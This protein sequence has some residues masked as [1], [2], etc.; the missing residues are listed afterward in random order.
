M[1]PMMLFMAI[2]AGMGGGTPGAL[3]MTMGFGIVTGF[4][5]VGALV[6]ALVWGATAHVLLSWTASPAGPMRRTFQAILFSAGAVTAT[7]V[8]CVGWYFG[9]IWWPVSAVLMVREAQRVSG[10]KAAFAVLAWPVVSLILGAFAYVAFIVAAVMAPRAFALTPTLEIQRVSTALLSYTAANQGAYP[11]HAVELVGD[12][13]L[14]GGDLVSFNS[15]TTTD[16][17]PIANATLTQYDAARAAAQ[18]ALDNQAA[19]AL[20]KDV[21]AHRVGDFVFCYHGLTPTTTFPAGTV[22]SSPWIVIQWPDPA[23]NPAPRGNDI[24]AIG[25]ADSSTQNIPFANFAGA[26]TAENARRTTIGLPPIPFPQTVTHI[27][28]AAASSSADP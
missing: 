10:G 12:S 14:I 5:A 3:S 21:V 26:L 4:A 16:D 9:W 6:Y 19:A 13:H 20:P 25:R 11:A 24:I 1:M 23:T 2:V 27:A 8:P 18:R 7:I 22:P 15:M 17:V 28:P